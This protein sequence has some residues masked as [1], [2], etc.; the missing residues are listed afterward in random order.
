MYK[1]DIIEVLGILGSMVL[2]VVVVLFCTVQ[3]NKIT[4][5]KT[6]KALNMDANYSYWTGCVVTNKNGD[7]FLLEQLRE[8]KK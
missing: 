3:V 6:S 1:E 2:I 7:N 5:Y 8:V 4:C